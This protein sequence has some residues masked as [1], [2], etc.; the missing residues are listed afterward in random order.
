MLPMP[1]GTGM[2]IPR[3]AATIIKKPSLIVKCAVSGMA[4]NTD[5]NHEVV[6]KPDVRCV[7]DE[8]APLVLHGFYGFEAFFQCPFQKLRTTSNFGD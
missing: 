4:K 7:Q 8:N 2:T 3:L 5:V 6:H 1:P